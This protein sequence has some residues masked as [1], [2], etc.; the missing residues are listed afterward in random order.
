MVKKT[1]VH[2]RDQYIKVTFLYFILLGLKKIN[3]VYFCREVVKED[4]LN[5]PFKNII[6]TREIDN[7]LYYCNKFGQKYF[8]FKTKIIDDTFLQIKYLTKLKDN[9]IIHAHMGHQGYYSIG[10]KNYFNCPLVV[11]F[12]GADMSSLSK[13]QTWK[14]K[15]KKLFKEADMF[16]VEGKIMRHEL[17]KLGAPTEKVKISKIPIPINSIPYKQK[18][19][20]EEN[21]K[22]L[23]CA[24]FVEK[25]GY[26]TGLKAIKKLHDERHD[27]KVGIIGDGPLKS[28]IY[29]FVNENQLVD[30]TQF[31][32][33]ILNKEIHQI[34]SNYDIFLHPSEEASDGDTEGGAP[35]I[36]L[37]MQANGL[38]IVATNHRDIPNYI[39]PE[40][41]YL[42]EEGDYEKVF[43]ELKRLITD[44]HKWDLISKVGRDFVVENHSI[45]QIGN[46][47]VEYYESLSNQK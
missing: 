5:M 25:K 27:I 17:I 28:E 43:V 44:S 6:K 36:I 23:M 35:T 3:N 21:I 31:Y 33:R 41:Q 1:I 29:N 11:T 38:P 10:L 45:Q 40:N 18:S 7:I 22:I 42:A 34:A 8:K 12:Y 4:M 37:E 13:Y 46:K 39:P 9:F 20:K 47:M 26:I 2:V 32:G 14:K 30:I 24:T 16:F 19:A 15:Y